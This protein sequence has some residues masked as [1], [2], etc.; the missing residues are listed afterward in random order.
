MSLLKSLNDMSYLGPERR[1]S[2]KMHEERI[3]NLE[4]IIY[5]NGTPGL[6]ENLRKVEAVIERMLQSAEKSERARTQII[7]GVVVGS[8]LAALNLIITVG[9]RFIN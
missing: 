7:G 6:A 4:H 3:K 1:L 2:C 5:G 8:I 9:S